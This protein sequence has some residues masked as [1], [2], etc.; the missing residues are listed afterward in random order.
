M[1]KNIFHEA[2]RR[3]LEKE[4]WIITKRSTRIRMGRSPSQN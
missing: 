2:V 1:A 4:Q 3:S